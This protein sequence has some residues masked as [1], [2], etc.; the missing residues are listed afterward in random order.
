M[1]WVQSVLGNA[2]QLSWFR[3]LAT[4]VAPIGPRESGL[5]NDVLQLQALP[6]FPFDKLALPVLLIHGADDSFVPLA[7]VEAV[8]K[9]IPNAELLAVPGTGHI[10]ELGPAS[11]PLPD[12][13]QEFLGRFHG[14]QGA[15]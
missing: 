15:P 5:K 9:R 6:S 4:T 3:D 13:I 12:K 14:G 2:A 1:K 10:P 8:K 11:A 7:E